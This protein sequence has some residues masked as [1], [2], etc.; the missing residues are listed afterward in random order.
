MKKKGVFKCVAFC[1][2][3][4]SLML[5][6][7][8]LGGSMGDFDVDLAI[9]TTERHQGL[10]NLTYNP[11]DGE[12]MVLWRTSGRVEEGGPNMYS[13]DGQRISPEGDLLGDPISLLAPWEGYSFWPK[14]THNPS[15]NEYLVTYTSGEGYEDWDT[16]IATIDSTGDIL[17]NPISPYPSDTLAT[18]PASAFNSEDGTYLLVYNDEI[19]GDADNLGF[20]LGEDA[21]VVRD[22][23]V[24]GSQTGEQL[25][26]QVAYNSKDDT[27]LVCWEDF[28]HQP[29]EWDPSDIWGVLLDADGDTIREIPIIDDYG[30]ADEGDQRVQQVAYNPDGNEFMVVWGDGGKPS[31]NNGGVMGQIVR[32][33]GTLKRS[34]FL[35]A[36]VA[37]SQTSPQIVYV[38]SRRQYFVIWDDTR[39]ATDPSAHW[40]LADNVDVY[41]RWLSPSGRPVG[42]EIPIC[43]W[44]GKQRSCKVAY[45]T[46]MER[47][48]VVWQE[49]NVDEFVEPFPPGAPGHLRAIPHSGRPPR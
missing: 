43:T 30:A 31:L 25:N 7:P 22:M 2:I 4:L 39:N 16:F 47:L 35:V 23:F 28:R 49:Y 38:E 46:V 5:P 36:D 18:H 21:N 20:I 27:Y 41:G 10:P 14:P 45:D 12:F 40:A 34:E 26:P 32:S 48:L 9:C 11:V 24:I 19:Y 44:E 33:N 13:I 3:M 1:F 37:G 6:E 8:C 29:T 17:S 15:R 42:D